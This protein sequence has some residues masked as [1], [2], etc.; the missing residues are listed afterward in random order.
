M[1][2]S[3]AKARTARARLDRLAPVDVVGGR[4]AVLEARDL[5][6]VRTAVGH[7]GERRDAELRAHPDGLRLVVR[8]AEPGQDVAARPL[9][10][11]AVAA[12]GAADEAAHRPGKSAE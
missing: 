2:T 9:E 6:V 8:E 1:T 5:D 4:R 11:D 3:L 10:E 7:R 12:D